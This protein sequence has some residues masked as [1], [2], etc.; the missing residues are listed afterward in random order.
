MA[1]VKQFIGQYRFLS[2]FWLDPIIGPGGLRFEHVEGAYQASKSNSY[3]DWETIRTQPTPGFAK[4]A[5]RK[6]KMREDWDQVK[7]TV[8]KQLLWRKFSPMSALSYK[9]ME[10]DG[11]IQEGNTW[12]DTFWGID[13]RTGQGFNHLGFMLMDIRQGLRTLETHYL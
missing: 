3:D 11:D 12:H 9:L 8:M 13:L 6:I 4:R 5:G 10:I 1:D 2:N 7:L